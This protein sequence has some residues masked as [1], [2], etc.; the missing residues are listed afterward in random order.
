[1]MDLKY[2]QAR[3]SNINFE[4]ASIADEILAGQFVKEHEETTH[5]SIID[6]FGNAVS[7]TTT[8]NG[9]FGNHVVVGMAGF[10]LNNEMDDFSSKP[11]FPNMYGLIGGEANAIVPAKRMLSS[12]TPTI[13]EKDGELFMVVGT[14]G[15]STIITSVFQAIL[16]VIEFDLNMQGAV[17]FQRFHHQWRPNYIQYEKGRFDAYILEGLDGLGHEVKER[18]AIGRTDAILVLEDGRLEGG[19]DLRGDDT[20]IGF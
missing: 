14:P 7:S 12:M 8:L 3:A 10:F 9:G 1:L 5:F 16:N 15:G 17:D 6:Q 11:G 18:S 20:A 2:N 4:K 13:V 19:A